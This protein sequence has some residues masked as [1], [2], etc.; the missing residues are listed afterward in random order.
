MRP[1]ARG[2]RLLI[3]WLAA[4]ALAG[5]LCVVSSPGPQLPSLA[6]PVGVALAAV[7]I[8]PVPR[9][10]LLAFGGMVTMVV[11]YS[12]IGRPLAQS[13]ALAAI[14]V[15]CG[16]LGA[17]ALRLARIRGIA[18]VAD[19]VV[20]GAVALTTGGLAAAA[21]GVMIVPQGA[22]WPY[23]WLV[24]ALGVA[25][26][27]PAALAVTD[28]QLPTRSA[29]YAEAA[30][31]LLATALLTLLAYPVADAIVPGRPGY[32]L[33]PLLLWIGLRLGL[34][35]V[36]LVSTVVA[37]VLIGRE[38][39]IGWYAAS[40]AGW[41]IHAVTVSVTVGGLLLLYGVAL[42]EEKRRLGERQLRANEEFVRSLVSNSPALV[43]VTRYDHTGNGVLGM[44]SE[45]L[46][47][48]LESSEED[49]LDRSWID[50]LGPAAGTQAQREDLQVLRSSSSR[51]SV[52][53]LGP[54]DRRRILMTTRFPL[55]TP[56]EGGQAVGM[57]AL[58]VTEHR[59]LDRIMRLT[60]DLS[61]V[62]MARMSVDAGEVGA[63]LD[64]NGS[65]GELLG[66]S[67]LQLRG[68]DLRNFLHPD[69][70]DVAWS[71]DAA[72]TEGRGAPR[73]V[74]IIDSTGR[75]I[76]VAVTISVVTG[77]GEDAFALAVVQ[78]VND[79]HEAERT[80]TYQAR[81]DAL[82]GLPNRY[83]LIERLEVALQRLWGTPSYVAVLF[84]DLDGFKSLND[85]LSHRAGDEVLTGAA[86][87]LRGAVRPQDTVARLGG[88]EFV[89]IAEQVA[90]PAEAIEI[91]ERLC[92][93]LRA[94]FH[95]QG[96][97]VGLSLSV[98]VS[99]TTDPHTSSEDL[100]R[101]ADLAMYRAK[102]G[103]R[104][105][106]EAYVETLET[107]AVARMRVQEYLRAAISGGSV[108]VKYQPIV[109]LDRSGVSA[110]EALARIPAPAAVS[111]AEFIETAE[112]NGLMG[113]LGA[114]VLRLVLADVNRW[115]NR[116]LQTRVHLNVSLS[117]LSE[118]AFPE[119]VF[120]RVMAAGVRPGQLCF[121]VSDTPALRRSVDLISALLRLRDLG[122]RVGLD[123]F[124][125]GY[126]G[127]AS[128][129][130]LSADYIKIDRSFID[131]LVTDREDRVMVEAMI[132]VAH[133]LD[134]RVIATGVESEAQVEVLQQLGCDEIQG[135]VHSAAVDAAQVPEILARV[136]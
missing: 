7:T 123:G 8:C 63:I 98:G 54:R 14:Q 57:V 10:L 77:G 132:R 128:L 52:Q 70:R 56:D 39:T 116:H 43:A 42:I 104:N 82:T 32:L 109:A 2:D 69:E 5:I 92:A 80:L 81:H 62:P 97:K 134:R 17:G 119:Q 16:L 122:F 111:T 112:K 114:E 4:L 96:R 26:P 129:K 73:E 74:R 115:Q 108:Q 58:D 89:V 124:G 100:L 90:T 125:A 50:T 48:L 20:F 46:V 127:L 55:R 117:Q 41:P 65:L 60:F 93:S 31:L 131:N 53:R 1:A 12:V 118:T 107:A 3:A 110:L 67:P 121:E 59:R 66:I 28:W 37:S 19:L 76:W 45:T 102:D 87:R 25:L 47:D 113:T 83:A 106:V 29:R 101:Q 35:V 79:R 6:L 130:I 126:A 71:P 22:L 36:G 34:R 44:V 9:G 86:D 64:A 11:A 99:V 18:T 51:V 15:A 84:C 133:D 68:Q 72:G 30:V 95:V 75:T 78:D 33:L 85:T 120:E 88:D 105:R 49:L 13:A 135:Y 23:W 94:P 27:G 24:T 38:L 103:G 136:G 61:P 91:G 21:M 40:A